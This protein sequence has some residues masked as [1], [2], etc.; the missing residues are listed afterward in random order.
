[1][2]TTRFNN[3]ILLAARRLQDVRTDPSP[4]GDSGR[5]HK[6]ALLQDYQNRAIR[7]IIFDAYKSLGRGFGSMIPEYVRTSGILTVSGA[8]ATRPADSW[9]VTELI[10]S[11]KT[12]KFV[13]IS[14]DEV[15][16]VTVGKRTLIVPSNSRPC[17]YQEGD[18]VVILPSSTSITG[19]IA[20]YIR[21]HQDIV[22]NTSLSTD[23][24]Y[25]L[26]APAAWTAATRQ[27]TATMGFPF[28]IADI[29]K[30]IMFKN[31]GIV[32][33]GRIEAWI[34]AVIV[35]VIGD[36]LPTGNLAAVDTVLVGDNSPDASDLIL[37]ATWDSV[38]VD[39]MVQYATLD[40]VRNKDA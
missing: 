13:P 6:S 11:A 14:D 4:T 2:A 18:K 16:D 21:V 28:A 40:A 30:L 39:K 20:R 36:G 19:V 24:N 22:V 37:K 31:A 1:M 33:S 34:S 23:G 35:T 7:E 32:Y 26:T 25:L 8:Q 15:F 10:D 17:F 29:N 38:I 3:N 12:L 5:R 27:L 9:I